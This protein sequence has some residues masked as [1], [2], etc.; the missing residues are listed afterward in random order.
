MIIQNKQ[1]DTV[2][3]G[4]FVRSKTET[5]KLITV[6]LQAPNRQQTSEEVRKR[7]DKT[8]VKYNHEKMSGSSFPAVQ[9]NLGGKLVRFVFKEDSSSKSGLNTALMECAQS[10]YCA[11]AQI[12]NG[13]ID[14]NFVLNH[15]DKIRPLIDIDKDINK[16]LE[17]M[18]NGW[19][20]SSELTANHLRSK[21]RSTNYIFHRNSRTTQNIYKKYSELERQERTFGHPDKWNPA[22]IWAIRRGATIMLNNIKS[23]EEFNDY[24][25]KLI[26]KGDVLGISLK[27]IAKAPKLISAN[28]TDAMRKVAVLAT[29]THH[30]E[31]VGYKVNTGTT[32]WTSSKN[33][34]IEVKKGNIAIG[35]ELRQSKGGA[36]VNGELKMKGTQARHGKIHMNTFVKIFQELGVKLEVPNQQTLNSESRTLDEDLI[37]KTLKLATKLDARS[38]VTFEEFSDFLKEKVKTD[39]DWLGSKY[40]AMLVIEAF[41]SLSKDK[42]ELAVERIYSNAAA[43]NE[44][45]GPFLKVTERL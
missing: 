2:L 29:P 33:C 15:I 1:L 23:F 22:D 25:R 9:C 27:K 43:S 34:K 42:Q 30:M 11:A 40:G 20:K 45:A 16:V 36:Q 14:S 6:I 31:V 41:A 35:I 3:K 7:L 17:A 19:R 37:G 32:N 26:D 18:D 5:S 12:G 24:L 38:H 10:I 13:P 39:S 8:R 44:L 4:L 28:T 21:L